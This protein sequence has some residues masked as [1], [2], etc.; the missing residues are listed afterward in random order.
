[1]RPFK[2]FFVFKMETRK[3]GMK[4]VLSVLLL[5]TMLSF[6][7]AETNQSDSTPA[8]VL[9]KQTGAAQFEEERYETH[10]DVN[11]HK[12]H[13]KKRSSD[14]DVDYEVYQGVVGRPGIDFPIYPRIPKTTFSCRSFGNGYFAD[15]ETD[16]QVFHI[17]EDGRKISFLC[18]N[19][20]IFQQSELTCDWWFKVNCLGSPGYY[21]DS[22][23]ILNK[24]RVQRIRPSVPV[25]GFNIVGGG[26][27]IK[28][29]VN[30]E[31]P[32]PRQS[33]KPERRFDSNE[34]PSLETVDFEDLSGEKQLKGE[35][36]QIPA[37]IDNNNNNDETQITAESG[38]FVDGRRRNSFGYEK[39]NV[40]IVETKSAENRGRNNGRNSAYVEGRRGNGNNNVDGNKKDNSSN[41]NDNASG[42]RNGNEKASRNG[43]N[44]S[45]ENASRNGNN[46]GNGNGNG[47]NTDNSNDRS[48][49]PRKGYNYQK[50][51]AERARDG[52]RGQQRYRED[53]KS[54]LNSQESKEVAIDSREFSKKPSLLEKPRQVVPVEGRAKS[55]SGSSI[56]SDESDSN[57]PRYST[58]FVETRLPNTTPY[59]ALGTYSTARRLDTTRSTPFYTPTVPTVAKSKTTEGKGFYIKGSPVVGSNIVASTPNPKRRVVSQDT[60]SNSTPITTLRPL[61]IGMRYNH[62]SSGEKHKTAVSSK[63]SFDVD[64]PV[65]RA[66]K[67]PDS[68]DLTT[69][70]TTPAPTGPTYLPRNAA[71][72]KTTSNSGG[73]DFLF[74]PQPLIDGDDSVTRNVQEMIKTINLL[75]TK[76]DDVDQTKFQGQAREGL[77]IPP[78]SG[79]DAL[80]SLAKYFANEQNAASSNS[81]SSSAE[82]K[83]IARTD[84]S[85]PITTLKYSLKPIKITEQV[86][87]TTA[88]NIGVSKKSEDIRTSLL[89]ERTVN[90]YSN[91]FGLHA[92][93]GKSTE[94]ITGRS[95]GTNGSGASNDQLSLFPQIGTTGATI[96]QL[97]EEPNSRKIAH[98]FSEAISSYLED[99][100]TFRAQLEAVRPTEP[101]I[102]SGKPNFEPVTATDRSLFNSGT[103]AT[104]L[105]TQSPIVTEPPATASSIAAEINNN[106]DFSTPSNDFLSTT[107]APDTTTYR[108]RF[109]D[110]RGQQLRKQFSAELQSALGESSEHEE[111]LHGEH[112]QSFV[113]PRNNRVKAAY[114]TDVGNK[115]TENPWNHISQTDFLDPLTI[116]DGLMKEPRTTTISSLNFAQ[117]D[118]TTLV[119]ATT[120]R[121]QLS[122][123]SS[124]AQRTTARTSEQYT[125]VGSAEETTHHPAA[126]NQSPEFDSWQEL[127]HAYNLPQES[128]PS[129]N[130]LQRI[131]NKLFGGLNESEALHLKNVMQQAEHNRQV[132]SLLLLL[133]QTCDDQNGRAL[134]RSRK[135]LL[136]ALIDMDGKLAN[137]GGKS[138][139]NKGASVPAVAAAASQPIISTTA[140]IVDTTIRQAAT[141]NLP[142]AGSTTTEA[143][144]WT[145]TTIPAVTQSSGSMEETTKFEIRV[146]DPEESTVNTIASSHGGS[147]GSGST[148]SNSD[149]RALELLKSLYSL[150]SKFTSR[151]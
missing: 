21:A 74:A 113:I 137:E 11:E 4:F 112:T 99:P 135:H 8:R 39:P 94:N 69:T 26:L 37:S 138:A 133:I 148:S 126:T 140:R 35:K 93:G 120:L 60:T 33:A 1:M 64:L 12:H 62:E 52:K 30:N 139:H 125:R 143:G 78:S 109:N 101:T 141:T 104:Y 58:R 57:E 97:A 27:N 98:V 56:K 5:V 121:G 43:N 67:R 75:K 88:T 3:L 55:R 118:T 51:S 86:D 84:A 107:D 19:G 46:S 79:P 81:V 91:L 130:G 23:E 145:T 16:C 50:E 116:N 149:E 53:V 7:S 28:A 45:K 72:P 134:E 42:S 132:L 41:S 24:Q 61:I 29:K 85:I 151:R 40:D 105:P 114:T 96:S 115:P 82:N 83:G 89:S 71:R 100:K 131:A 122:V 73:D 147:S 63:S 102:V 142:L 111:F 129:S 65:H 106:F 59:Q 124:D 146:E 70:S 13:L 117:K 103:A 92:A 77:D 34:E 49:T 9:A 14:E 20:T 10:T 119:P 32:R 44:N 108:P 38:S 123:L 47:N 6:S 136:N 18:P 15:M 17:C 31:V 66:R 54:Q 25:Q 68:A 22:A 150:A 90:Q 110:A 87:A 80:V 76:F 95:S 128:L 48:T 36:T 127:F 2:D 144:A